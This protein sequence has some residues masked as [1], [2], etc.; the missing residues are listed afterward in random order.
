ME[1]LV[2]I[3]LWVSGAG[4]SLAGISTEIDASFL[5]S[6]AAAR[7]G[8]TLGS[9]NGAA[10]Y[11]G[12]MLTFALGML[13]ADL[14]RLRL[15]L[16]KATFA[17][18]GVAL[19]FT[20][21]RGAWGAFAFALGVLCVAAWW[22]GRLSLMVPVLLF[23]VGVLLSL[24]FQDAIVSRLFGDDR[25]SAYAR[26]PL[27]TL[28]LRMIADNP[29]LG[30][31]ANNFAI[32]MPDYLTPEISS[33]WL[34]TVHNRYLLI[35]AESGPGALL[36]FLG[37]FAAT[38]RRG[39]RCWRAGDRLI[40]P[41]GLGLTTALVGFMLHMYAEAFNGRPLMSLVM[42]FAGLIVAMANLLDADREEA[43]PAYGQSTWRPSHA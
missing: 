38:L 41:I 35:W 22:R 34:Y 3:G 39:W 9:P 31:G 14:A 5:A 10:G 40:S 42:V 29:L 23:A 33:A 15:W 19:V 11:L 30:V 2:M 28:A 13:L 43:A 8:G 12:V 16:A 4:F 27:M 24:F 17:F 21:S 32:R 1:S 6:D 37:F 25:G 18:C 20:L 36:A 26:M 7:L